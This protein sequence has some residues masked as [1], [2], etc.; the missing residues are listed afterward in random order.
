MHTLLLALLTGTTAGVAGIWSRSGAGSRGAIRL[1]PACV[2]AAAIAWSA[3]DAALV[4]LAAL[5]ASGGAGLV[6]A[7]RPGV[8][9]GVAAAAGVSVAVGLSLALP[10][11]HPLAAATLMYAALAAVATASGAL[12]RAPG[13]FPRWKQA[14]FE[15]ANIPAAFVLAD[16][17]RSSSVA[18]LVST[19]V[20]LVLAAYASSALARAASRLTAARQTLASRV[21]E[22][23][24][25]HS[26]GRDIVT[27]LDP[28]RVFSI[29]ERECR[30]LFDVDF[31]FIGVL[32]RTTNDIRIS[33]RARS[34]DV[35]HQTRRP[36][37]DG[38]AS[39]IVREKRALRVDDVA[40]DVLAFRP[41]MVDTTVRS[42]LA[43]PLLVDDH[44]VGVL[45]AQ[46]RRT[47]AYDDHHLSVLATIAQQIAVAIENA[48]HY[49]LTT[50]DSL[51]GLYLRDAFFRRVEDEYTRARRYA[52]SFAILMLDLDGFKEINDLHGHAAGDRYLRAAAAAIKEG[53]RGADLACRYGGD[54]FCLL[55]PVTELDGARAIAERVRQA[56]ASLAVSWD[57]AVLRATV[58]IGVASYPE[59]D[60]GDLKALLLRADQAL[61][62]AKRAGRDRVVPYAA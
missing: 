56:V 3:L 10:P 1:A 42:I 60:A 52:S 59:H 11:V 51:T 34:E 23:A 7:W 12:V 4:A 2:V 62:H 29:V 50:T 57:G 38:L 35:P 14:L 49:A 19:L 53:L 13:G 43:V 5:A 8:R 15:L 25:L 17:L 39:W 30:K 28:E 47:H 31:F 27:T 48:R 16:Q 9:A 40:H 41:E 55:L 22:L 54:E 21:S 45:S 44:V 33:Y 36:L 6:G 58:S 32:D 26:I 18:P 24:T 37:G 46:S 20:L 61:Y